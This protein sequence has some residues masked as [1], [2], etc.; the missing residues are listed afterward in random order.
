MRALHDVLINGLS[1][2]SGGGFTVGK[3]LL[4]H[5]A[6]A[7]PDW[8]F[9]LAIIGGHKLHEEITRESL[10]ANCHIMRAPS[11]AIGK[12]ARMR[13]ERGDFVAWAKSNDVTRVLQLN[14][15]VI[16]TMK[17]P[18]LSHNQD[19]W[20]YRPQAYIH[21]KEH[22]TAFL[23]R[24]EQ[25][26]A[27]KLAD[28]MGFTSNYLRDLVISRAGIQPKRAEVFYNGLA[29]SWLER[30]RQP[31]PDWNSRPMEIVTVSNV[32]PYK[33]NHLVI[34]ALPAL[35]KRPGLSDLLYRIVGHC[36]PVFREQLESLAKS[37][38]VAKHVIVH[39][40]L[41]DAQTQQYYRQAKAFVMMSVCESFGIP[42][43]EAMTFGTPV[44]TSDCCAMPEVC[45]DAA[46]LSPVDDVASLARNLEIALTDA[47]RVE[48][49]RQRGGKRVQKF[50]WGDTA[51]AMARAL[52]QMT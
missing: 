16:P 51:E 29:E 46:I 36:E 21:W 3:E 43:I 11:D 40:R 1:M 15:M 8:K 27:L 28:C 23:K 45:G 50:R 52:E 25:K 20:P 12:V 7:R 41:D 6:I 10:P 18:T 39:G 9:T 2:G 38:G 19:P 37:L 44:V 30:A 14:G 31:L 4:R 33:R 22:V 32:H 42:A 26:R 48:H 47:T 24:R 13:Y 49:M 35:L 5:L 34:Q 17:I